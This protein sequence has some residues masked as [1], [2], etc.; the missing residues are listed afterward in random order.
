[1]RNCNAAN[2][3][4]YTFV[5]IMLQLIR[6]VEALFSEKSNSHRYEAYNENRDIVILS[7]YLV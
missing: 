2:Q 5:N 7:N 6:H 4:R 3:P 1:M